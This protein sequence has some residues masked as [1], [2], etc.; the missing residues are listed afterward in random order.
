[1]VW[2]EI[3]VF[4]LRITEFQK[5]NTT[6]HQVHPLI[7]HVATGPVITSIDKDLISS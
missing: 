7:H 1:M 4:M 3:A 5:L 2:I 6:G